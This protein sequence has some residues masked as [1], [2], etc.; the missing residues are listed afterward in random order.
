M[1]QILI[2][3]LEINLSTT[4]EGGAL[5][6]QGGVTPKAPFFAMCPEQFLD[7]LPSPRL[8]KEHVM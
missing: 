4:T 8:F 6:E 7:T 5:L 1:K 2:S 3:L